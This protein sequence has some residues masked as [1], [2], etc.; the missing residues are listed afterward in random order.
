MNEEK[1]EENEDALFDEAVELV[2]GEKR[3]SVSLLQRRLKINYHQASKL[4]DKMEQEEIVGPYKGAK[5]REVL[6]NIKEWKNR[7]E[8]PASQEGKAV[9]A[10]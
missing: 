6:I 5:A 3:G 4:I 1:A 10:R 7:K 9:E 2:L 8:L